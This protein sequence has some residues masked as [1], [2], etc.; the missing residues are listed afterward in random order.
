M[1]EAIDPTLGLNEGCLKVW[2]QRATVAPSSLLVALFLDLIGRQLVTSLQTGRLLLGGGV[3]S[4]WSPTGGLFE[5]G[6]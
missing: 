4:D 6:G 1:F 3:T 2:S 5:F